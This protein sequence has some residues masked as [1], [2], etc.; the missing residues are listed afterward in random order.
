MFNYILWYLNDIPAWAGTKCTAYGCCTP[1]TKSLRF[2][3]VIT[4]G[5]VRC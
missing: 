4:C 3:S 5:D 2:R 1:H